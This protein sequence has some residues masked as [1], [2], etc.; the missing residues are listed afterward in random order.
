V[1]VGAAEGR[2]RNGPRAAVH[3]VDLGRGGHLPGEVRVQLV[4]ADCADGVQEVRTKPAPSTQPLTAA[5]TR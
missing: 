2:L 4:V 3:P 1:R 5:C